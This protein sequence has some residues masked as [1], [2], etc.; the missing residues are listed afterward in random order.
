MVKVED[1]G[2]V[3]FGRL[4]ALVIESV[5]VAGIG[6]RTDM[7][8]LELAVMPPR[9]IVAVLSKLWL[10]AEPVVVTSTTTFAKLGS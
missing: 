9:A 2:A 7:D 4:A 1:P 5:G 3:I 10:G 8:A 6:P